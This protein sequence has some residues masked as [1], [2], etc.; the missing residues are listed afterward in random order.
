MVDEGG[1]EG[2]GVPA[3][4]FFPATGP[5]HPRKS[6]LQLSLRKAL[7]GA[8]RED[9]DGVLAEDADDGHVLRAVLTRLEGVNPAAQRWLNPPPPL[10]ISGPYIYIYK[11]PCGDL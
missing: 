9:P 3:S 5:F 11:Q 6:D 4:S 10:S 8:P 2:G 7:L 1:P